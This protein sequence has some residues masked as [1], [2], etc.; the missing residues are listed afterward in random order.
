MSMSRDSMSEEAAAEELISAEL[1]AEELAA[2]ERT[3]EE[4]AVE[5]AV[6]TEDPPVYES[7]FDTVEPQRSARPPKL[8]KKYYEAELATLQTEL[9]K[10]QSYVKEEGLKVVVIFEGRDAAGKGGVI[11][12]ITERLNPRICRV[13]ALGTATER[14]KTQWW[15]QRYVSR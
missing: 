12:R 10:L 1:A 11:K 15:F 4:L 2:E 7:V 9:V 3:A 14:E 13:E 6:V 8:K 5:E